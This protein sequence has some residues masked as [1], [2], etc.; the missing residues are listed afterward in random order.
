[1][2]T[3]LAIVSLTASAVCLLLLWRVLADNRRRAEA[4]TAALS[5]A[6]DGPAAPS[7]AHADAAPLF[8]GR[9][10]AMQGRP[11][12]KVAIGFAM[13]VTVIVAIAMTSDRGAVS[14]PPVAE[15][16]AETASLELI[17]MRHARA[18]DALTVT[19]LVRNPRTEPAA[20]VIAVV[21][22]FDRGGDFVASGRAPLEFPTLGRGDESPF[23]VTIPKVP[24]VGR[25]RVSFRTETGVLRHVD[26]RD[27]GD[28]RIAAN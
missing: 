11:L 23:Q 22:A 27:R 20:R 21:L 16:P 15:A 26:R 17:S 18:G 28:G 1:M 2:M 6:I 10:S 9:T 3:F 5:S 14:A 13:A 4:R 24:D 7:P 12:L 19:G 8:E 25:Y